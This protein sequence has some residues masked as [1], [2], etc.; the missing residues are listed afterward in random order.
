[1]DTTRLALK[2]MTPELL[3]HEIVQTFPDVYEAAVFAAYYHR[4]DTRGPRGK[5]PADPY[6]AHPYRVTLR[7]LRG[8]M[9]DEFTAK[10]ALLHDVFEDHAEDIHREEGMPADLYLPATFGD[11]TWNVIFAVSNPPGKLTP[12]QYAEHVL[13]IIE[14]GDIRAF[15]VKNSDLSDN[16]LSLHHTPGPRRGRLARKYLPVAEPAMARLRTAD[17]R[18]FLSPR[19]ATESLEMWERGLPKLREFAQEQ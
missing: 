9:L 10:A 1:M 11:D 18:A 4:H 17:A 13:E 7:L 12:E 3:L 6:I 19:G 16:A 2:D 8:G 15:A 14:D 5:L